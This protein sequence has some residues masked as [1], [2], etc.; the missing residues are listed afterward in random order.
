MCVIGQAA[1][2]CVLTHETG[3]PPPSAWDS[4]STGTPPLSHAS[5]P[6]SSAWLAIHTELYMP[7]FNLRLPDDL[8]A[9]LDQEAGRTGLTKTEIVK[10]G[11]ELALKTPMR[12]P[13]PR[14]PQPPA[15]K[16]VPNPPQEARCRCG[17]TRTLGARCDEC[18]FVA[19]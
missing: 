14:A 7:Q 6:Y 12:P 19:R 1:R 8:I 4:G 2:P 13:E 18:G 11:I 10:R 16:R 3:P 17:Q 9:R 5:P 15:T